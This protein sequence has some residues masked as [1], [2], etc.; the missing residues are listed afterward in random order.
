MLYR[1]GLSTYF[2]RIISKN[3][4]LHVDVFAYLI[5]E[6]L[7]LFR[8]VTTTGGRGQHLQEFVFAARPSEPDTRPAQVPTNSMLITDLELSDPVRFNTL[9]RVK[10]Y[11]R[12][13]TQYH[14][15]F[16]R[17][18]ADTIPLSE[19]H[20][21]RSVKFHYF[22]CPDHDPTQ[23]FKNFYRQRRASQRLRALGSDLL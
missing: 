1:K 15:N 19:G 5:N 12:W 17:V 11:G 6:D 20:R 2:H 16:M 14:H 9:E 13:A 8:Y 22:A 18:I 21:R 23:G 3:T 10:T 7:V 4:V